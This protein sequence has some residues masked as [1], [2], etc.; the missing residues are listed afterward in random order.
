[1][2]YYEPDIP[3]FCLLRFYKLFCTRTCNFGE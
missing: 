2:R 3:M 1:M